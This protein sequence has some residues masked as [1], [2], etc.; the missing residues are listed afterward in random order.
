MSGGGPNDPAGIEP[1]ASH[2]R[3]AAHAEFAV[4]ASS[5]DVAAVRAR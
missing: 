1:D 2:P 3:R 5:N 4:E